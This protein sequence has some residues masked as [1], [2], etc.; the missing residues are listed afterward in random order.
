MG[1]QAA[2][3]SELKDEKAYKD[4]WEQDKQ[5]VYY[6]AHLTPTYEASAKV[7]SIQAEKEYKKDFETTKDKNSFDV[8]ATS[9][10]NDQKKIGN[11][12]SEVKYKD[13]FNKSK[14]QFNAEVR[15]KAPA[16]VTIAYPE[17]QLAKKMSDQASQGKYTKEAKEMMKQVT[18]PVDTPQY[19]LAKQSAQQ[20]SD[21]EYK[22]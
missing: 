11:I 8:T 4:E 18:L 15:G 19:K 2:K 10:Y 22:K 17:T 3:A 16:D 20:A 1:K 13:E 12:T 21:I 9:Q 7:K 6:P 5:M 14:G